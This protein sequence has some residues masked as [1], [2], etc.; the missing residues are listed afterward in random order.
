M[1][2]SMTGFGKGVAEGRQ[3]TVKVE[4]KSLNCKFFEV[5]SKLPPNLTMLEDKIRELLQRRISRGRLTL[6]LSYTSRVTKGDEVHIDKKIAKQYHNRIKALQKFLGIKGDIE[7]E[8]II[9]LPGVIAYHPQA[10]DA[11][12]LWPLI[13]KALVLS[14]EDITRSKARE[15]AMLG[16]NLRQ[17][18]KTVEA[19]LK[20][21]QK[22]APIVAFDYKKRLRQNVK[23][24]TG[25]RKIH[26]PERIE[27]EA[28]IFAR[29]CD[30]TEE[31][32]RLCAHISG[33]RKI[34][35]NNGETGRRLDFVAQE[36]YR[37]ANTIGAKANDFFIAKEIIKIKS[38]IE[39]IRE[40]AQ[41]V[42]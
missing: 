16:K 19:G 9:A 33:F 6:F 23:A 41:N 34:L 4:I 11:K 5:V 39:K 26:S 37:E 15:G 32:H 31:M 40:Q 13:S 42:E 8:Q 24:L 29:N 17:I 21:I 22:R 30:V 25:T 38:Q 14:I 36:M 2:R 20:K 12:K 7:L 3:G 1:L 10:D 18:V 27:E 35:S 28:A